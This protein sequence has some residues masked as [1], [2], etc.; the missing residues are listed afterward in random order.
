MEKLAFWAAI[1]ALFLWLAIAGE[2]LSSRV[3]IDSKLLLLALM[4][5]VSAA[6]SGLLLLLRR[7]IGKHLES[8]SEHDQEIL[9]AADP[10]YRYA[11]TKK[12]PGRG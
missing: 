6:L 1:A 11:I 10:E 3:G 2:W 9:R 5:L 7:N 4:L 8:Y 12:M